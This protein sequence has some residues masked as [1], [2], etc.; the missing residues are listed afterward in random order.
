MKTEISERTYAET[1]LAVVAAASRHWHNGQLYGD[2]PYFEAHIEKAVANI[3]DTGDTVGD[4]DAR[5]VTYLHDV[6]ED[7]RASVGDVRLFLYSLLP[8]GRAMVI[9]FALNR[10]TRRESESYDEFIERIHEGTGLSIVLAVRAKIA[11]IKANMDAPGKPS[12]KA[13]YTKALTK[14]TPT[15]Q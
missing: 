11:D 4:L 15:D 5:I 8:P 3:E 12:L 2:Q 1:I 6:I 13:R 10:L 9:V 7:H 14:L